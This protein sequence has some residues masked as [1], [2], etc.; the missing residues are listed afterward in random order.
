MNTRRASLLAALFF[1]S[2]LSAQQ[3][4]TP[5]NRVNLPTFQQAID[6][7]ED[8]DLL[9][10]DGYPP[11]I[12]DFIRVDRSVTIIGGTF[13]T[14]SYEGPGHG[15]PRLVGAEVLGSAFGGASTPGI[16][17]QGFT[18]LSIEASQ[19]LG[20]S[21]GQVDGGAPAVRVLDGT[22]LAFLHSTV[23]APYGQY[24]HWEPDCITIAVPPAVQSPATVLAIRSSFWGG[25]GLIYVLNTTACPFGPFSTGE[26][27]A[28]I[29]AH[30][31]LSYDSAFTGGT[32][33]SWLDHPDVG[34]AGPALR[35]QSYA[36]LG[37]RRDHV[38]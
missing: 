10:A 14:L 25:N 5:S 36:E 3:Q 18:M 4:T 22:T 8:G 17:V 13:N 19:V 23:R 38:R 27:G 11:R 28:G 15:N 37:L 34:P 33:C 29:E 16:A 30:R 21:G 1:G 32:G 6:S 2:L 26:G 12:K 20:T 24:V 9:Y 31:V 7:A 35:V